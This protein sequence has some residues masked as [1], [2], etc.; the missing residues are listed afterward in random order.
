LSMPATPAHA[1]GLVCSTFTTCGT[2]VVAAGIQ[3]PSTVR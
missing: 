3:Q 2:G 1:S